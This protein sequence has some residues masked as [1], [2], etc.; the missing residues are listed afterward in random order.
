MYLP[1]HCCYRNKYFKTH[2]LQTWVSTLRHI[3][4]K[5]YVFLLVMSNVLPG[6]LAAGL[7]E[8]GAVKGGAIITFITN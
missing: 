6:S 3:V 5:K 4:W 2:K 1:I 7:S 8:Y